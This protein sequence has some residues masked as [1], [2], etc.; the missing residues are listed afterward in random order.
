MPDLRDFSVRDAILVLSRI[1]LKYKV[2][3]SGKVI[4]QSIQAGDAIHKGLYC[5]LDCKETVATGAVVY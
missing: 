2:N 1:G 5:V 4:A 3:G